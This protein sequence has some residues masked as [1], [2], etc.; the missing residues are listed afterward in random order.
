[1]FL[2]FMFKK[3]K[4]LRILISLTNG[5]KSC[6]HF[7]PPFVKPI[8][9]TFV[10]FYKLTR[11]LYLFIYYCFLRGTFLDHLMTIP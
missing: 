4:Q 10:N 5:K 11:T 1:M 9:Y 2:K 6:T 3:N 7:F 8:F